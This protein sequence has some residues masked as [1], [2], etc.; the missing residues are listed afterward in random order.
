MAHIEFDH[1]T[2]RYGDVVAVRDITVTV[3]DR[4]FFCFFGPPSSGKSTLLRLLLGIEK[5]S[6]GEIRI[7]GKVVNARSPA[8]RNLAM[9]FQNLALFPHMS[10]RDNLRFPL[11]ERGVAAS[12]IGTRLDGIADKLHISH[13]LDKRPA[14]LSGGE[15]QRVAIGR[16]LM[17]EATAYLMDDPIS[18]LDA[19]LREEMRV[20]LKRLQ[21]EIGHTFIY[22][23][24]DQ[25][26]AMSVAD[27]MAILDHGAIRQI[28]PPQRIYD[29]PRSR[30]VASIVG[31]PTMNFVAGAFDGATGEFRSADGTLK[32]ALAGRCD[33]GTEPVDLPF[34]PEDTVLGA[35][36]GVPARVVSVEP[37][38][39]FSI[40]IVDCGEQRLK[41][42]VKGQA[43]PATG[44]VVAVGVTSSRVAL[45]RQ[46][47][48]QRLEL[49]AYRSAINI[50]QAREE[51]QPC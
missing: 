3:E 26:E 19:R 42:M 45:F 43:T 29:W 17:R 48:G 49:N 27:R 20:E 35:E 23:T 6:D 39:A 47:D 21:R 22:V 13:L 44:E 36:T 15:R 12:I 37:L 18:A 32:V 31:A 4:E 28:D 33:G 1:V 8:E 50:K 34:R 16:A 5:P 30:Y 24:H 11:V 51:T 9:V 25:E 14:Q 38:G 10:A 46:S 7:D 2:K 41:A 40:V